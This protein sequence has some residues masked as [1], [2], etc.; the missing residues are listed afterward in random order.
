MDEIFTLE[1]VLSLSKLEAAS[2]T[3][4]T[5]HGRRKAPGTAGLFSRMYTG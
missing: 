4:L 1:V 5:A 2:I 3:A